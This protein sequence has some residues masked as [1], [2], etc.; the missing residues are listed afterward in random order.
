MVPLAT[1][2]MRGKRLPERPESKNDGFR[3]STISGQVLVDKSVLASKQS[4]WDCAVLTSVGSFGPCANPY[5]PKKCSRWF[6]GP[7]E[8][9][10]IMWWPLRLLSSKKKVAPSPALFVLESEGGMPPENGSQEQELVWAEAELWYAPAT[11]RMFLTLEGER[12]DLAPPELEDLLNPALKRALFAT[13]ATGAAIALSGDE[14][15]VCLAA[16]GTAPD[17]GMRVDLRFGF[18]GMCVR[19]G[20]ILCCDDAETDPRVD[21][22]ACRRLGVRSMIAVPLL[23]HGKA[24][25]I[26]E[27]LSSTT[28][29]FN[30]NDIR[31]T[32]MLAKMTVEA[33]ALVRPPR[34]RRR[35]QGI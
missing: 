17:L 5:N 28:H 13:Q 22:A 11:R 23:H 14:G 27:V 24:I 35:V 9:Y 32:N 15:M 26:L 7:A 8:A 21:L 25:G 10:K 1:F 2:R 12:S 18:S 19:K 6:G 3:A 29:A 16:E 4:T 34:T 33:V 20:R 30:D 31:H